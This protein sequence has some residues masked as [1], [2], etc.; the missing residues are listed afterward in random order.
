MCNFEFLS[1]ETS[2]DACFTRWFIYLAGFTR[3]IRSSSSRFSSVKS[4]FL[5]PVSEGFSS[6]HFSLGDPRCL[7]VCRSAN[8]PYLE[9]MYVFLRISSSF[10][11]SGTAVCA[12]SF[13]RVVFG[14]N[15]LAN[16]FY[17]CWCSCA[18]K[19]WRSSRSG[20]L[21]LMNSRVFTRDHLK[22]RIMKVATTKQALFWALT[23][24][25]ITLS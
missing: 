12:S 2:W 16:N 15:P 19:D 3:L 14:P 4:P 9:F 25:I 17:S 8:G 10:S 6:R 7:A 1:L 18:K 13:H 23:D 22:R 11:R 21:E 5:T 20:L 24:W